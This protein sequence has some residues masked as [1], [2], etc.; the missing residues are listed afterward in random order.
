MNSVSL[1]TKQ[2]VQEIFDEIQS[3]G[4]K[5][6]PIELFDY[7]CKNPDVLTTEELLREIVI[8]ST[9]CT[10]TDNNRKIKK[11]LVD[12]LENEKIPYSDDTILK[13][14]G[15]KTN[16]SKRKVLELCVALKLDYKKS[17]YFLEKSGNEYFSVR[18]ETDFMFLYCIVNKRPYSE[19]LELESDFNKLSINKHDST[20][21]NDR[22]YR[23][24]EDE[25]HSGDTTNLLERLALGNW[26]NKETFFETCLI[27]NKDKFIGY[28][29]NALKQFYLV[30]NKAFLEVILQRLRDKEAKTI[31]K[32]SIAIEQLGN[33]LE[34]KTTN[35]ELAKNYEKIIKELIERNTEY[36]DLKYILD[37]STFVSNVLSDPMFLRTAIYSI[38]KD[39]D[40][41]SNIRNKED[42]SK[43]QDIFDDEF[44]V[45]ATWGENE[46]KGSVSRKSIILLFFI[47]YICHITNEADKDDNAKI[48]QI[49]FYD[50][51]DQLSSLL[52][53]CRMKNLSTDNKFDYLILQCVSSIPSYDP[54][55]M[56][57][58]NAPDYDEEKANIDTPLELFNQVLGLALE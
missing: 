35:N 17:I 38:G 6:D 31:S 42:F 34:I 41:D 28:S 54:Y 53:K 45:K 29:F 56:H 43:I 18:N 23:I 46:E 14:F 12:A 49:D 2:L 21:N 9:E 13:W 15:N 40:K 52:V 27:P 55:P 10:Q 44:P 24:I 16:M 33:C 19:L 4:Q 22:N 36:A 8:E 37:L 50:F 32:F 3:I 39:S 11:A 47:Q 26:E 30:K 20:E 51:V 5:A 57:D 1:E 48:V 58:R 7:L 25:F